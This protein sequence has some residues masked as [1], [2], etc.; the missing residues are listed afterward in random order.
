MTGLKF[1]DV[2]DDRVVVPYP[3]VCVGPESNRHATIDT[4]QKGQVN[5]NLE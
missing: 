4:K 3:T 2:N 5:P 1:L